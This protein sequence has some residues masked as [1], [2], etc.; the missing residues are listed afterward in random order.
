MEKEK[1]KNKPAISILITVVHD[2]LCVLEEQQKWFKNL[3]FPG[4]KTQEMCSEVK[5]VSQT[6]EPPFVQMNGW[7][8]G[9]SDRVLQI[10]FF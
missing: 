8:L 2:T 7:G 1:K 5:T 6:H 10:F 4:A 9:Q 3:Q